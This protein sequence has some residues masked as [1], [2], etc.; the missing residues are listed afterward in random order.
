MLRIYQSILSLYDT[1]LIGLVATIFLYPLISYGYHGQ[2]IPISLDSAE[3]ISLDVQE[4]QVNIVAN[5]T[6]NDPS[7]ANQNINSVMKVY[8]PNGTLIKTS[9]SADGF[10]VNQTGVQR[11]ATSIVNNTSQNVIAV[12]QFT[13]LE[14]TLPV[15]NPLQVNLTLAPST[16]ETKN[17]IAALQ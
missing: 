11:H 17:E 8:L 10:I 14:K 5:Y 2:E 12:V 15:S 9:S 4:N 13:N 7:F 1:L 6:I 16:S 3:F